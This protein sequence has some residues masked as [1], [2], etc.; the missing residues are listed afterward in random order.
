MRAS[1]SW[2]ARKLR[3]LTRAA[4]DRAYRYQVLARFGL[5]KGAFQIDATTFEN[6]YPEIFDHVRSVLGANIDARILSFGCATGEEVFTLR[7][8]FPRAQ[9]KG[10]DINPGNIAACRRRPE[11]RSDPGLS[12]EVSGTTQSE[13]D[14]A[15]DAIFSMAVLRHGDLALPGTDRCD[16]LIAFADFARAVADFERCLKPGGFLG[17]RFSN[18]LVAATPSAERFDVALTLPV[19]DGTPVFGPNNRLIRGARNNEALFRKRA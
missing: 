9:I 5:A 15:Y 8:Y 17:V 14:G 1:G 18:F 13:P 6:R 19:P 3:G 4:A 11:A 7:R 16:H 10:I 2:L 12:F